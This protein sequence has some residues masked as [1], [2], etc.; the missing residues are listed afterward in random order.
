MQNNIKANAMQLL[1]DTEVA[2]I[3]GGDA[4][5]NPC[6]TVYPGWLHHIGSPIINIPV[7]NIPVINLPR[8][9]G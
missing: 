1:S 6:G 9:G 5:D 8:I 7:I 4:I 3:S 2:L